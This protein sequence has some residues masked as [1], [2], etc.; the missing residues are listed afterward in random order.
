MAKQPVAVKVFYS[1]QWNDR[2]TDTLIGSALGGQDIT[3]T[4]GRA[5]E[6]EQAPPA[7]C[8]LSFK[9]HEFNPNNPT[10]PLYGLIGRNTPLR[11][12]LGTAHVGAGGGSAVDTTSL[13]APSVIAP[14]AAGY[15]ICAWMVPDPAATI[16]QPGGMNTNSQVT[17]SQATMRIG[18]QL[19]SSSGATGTRT[20]TCS[21]S[22]D[23][24]SASIFINGP[25]SDP[26]GVISDVGGGPVTI[27]GTAGDWWLVVGGFVD[28][29]A[30]DPADELRPPAAPIDTDGGGWIPLADSGSL[31]VGD[32]QAEHLRLIMWVKQVKTTNAAHTITLPG[33]STVSETLMTVKRLPGAGVGSWSVRFAG[34]VA[35]WTPKQSLGGPTIP[36]IRWVEVVA[37][38]ITRRLAQGDDPLEPAPQRYAKLNGAIGFWPLDDPDGSKQARAVIGQPMV[39]VK[40]PPPLSGRNAPEYGTGQVAPWLPP[41]IRGVSDDGAIRAPVSGGTSGG[42]AVDW[43]YRADR[44]PGGDEPIAM[45][46]IVYCEGFH[47][48]TAWGSDDIQLGILVLDDNLTLLGSSIVTDDSPVRDGQPHY[49]RLRAVEAAGTNVD[50]FFDIDGGANEVSLTVDIGVT[51]TPPAGAVEIVWNG[52]T[53]FTTPAAISQL[54]L[55]NEQPPD[56]A[57]VSRAWLG[58][59]DETTDQRIARLA[60]EEDVPLVLVGD[61]ALGSPAGPQHPDGF[62]AVLAEAAE[63]GQS[64]LGDAREQAAILNR[65]IESLYN[66]PAALALDYDQ[67]QVAPPLDPVI[68]DQA[69]RNDITAKGRTGGEHR[70]TLDAGALSTQPPPDG[71]GRVATEV[72]VNV[73][74]PSQLGDQTGWRLLLGTIPGTRFPQISVDLDAAPTL[75][76]AAGRVDVGDRITVDN[77]PATISPDLASLLVQ[78]YTEVIGSR[79][80][81]ITYNCV[82]YEPYQ[83][84]EV[85]HADYGVLQSDSAVTAEALDTTETGVDIIC[86]AGPDWVHEVDFDIEIAGEKVTVTAVGAMS[87]TFPNRTCT[88][89]VTRSVNGVVKSHA[90]GATIRFAD[91]AYIG[92]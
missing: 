23:Y 19:L 65:P 34:E 50:L 6:Q 70:A 81:R 80:R 1:G 71:V 48:R 22:E 49:M 63:T 38:G 75:A 55:W 58:N 13:V 76:D 3:I 8:A 88:L 43:I 90:S 35:S 26:T 73:A 91:R 53:G 12:E 30:A 83:I 33:T 11:V 66:Q 16:T 79:R 24:A 78:G 74:S 60:D 4:R 45:G 17:G 41:S 47:V 39:H 37:A 20:A 67:Q 69:T 14:T 51:T 7:G 5:N 36:P 68:D 27:D 9:G 54:A 40:A 59:A 29:A 56:E 2:T 86:G 82:P 87:G 84:G 25:T 89:T 21:V 72:T 31:A 42:W 77:L 44:S 52:G 61:P 28:L 64:I 57:E 32:A 15:L 18:R 46:V 85:A 62:L 10:S 92:L